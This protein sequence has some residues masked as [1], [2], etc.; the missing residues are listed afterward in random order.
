MSPSDQE[1]ITR[2]LVNDDHQAFGQ[3]ITRHQS[4]LR[5]FLRRL[6]AGDHALADDLAQDACLL[7]FQKL[8]TF[9]GRASFAAWLRKLAY[10]RFL[11][12]V[13]T[14]A[15]KYETPCSESWQKLETRDNVEADILAETLMKYLTV[16]ERLVITLNCSE[17]MSHSEIV[18]VTGMPLGTVKSHIARA[19]KKLNAL[20]TASQQVA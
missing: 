8:H 15:Q 5:H 1:L 3:L 12:V 10:H 13:Q 20:L 16:V 18:E 6:T 14:G 11:R 17:G 19:K 2:V 7:A 9:E 4:G